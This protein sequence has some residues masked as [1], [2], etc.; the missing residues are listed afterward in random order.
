MKLFTSQINSYKKRTPI[1]IRENGK[2]WPKLTKKPNK[3]WDNAV[4]K[5]KKVDVLQ[6][7]HQPLPLLKLYCKS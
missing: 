1:E 6:Q 4:S 3:S 2:T 7:D 5:E